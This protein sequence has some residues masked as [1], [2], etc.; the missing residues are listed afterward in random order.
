[1]KPILS[2]GNSIVKTA[3][4]GVALASLALPTLSQV[5]KPEPPGTPTATANR[6]AQAE[7][8]IIALTSN[9]NTPL[10]SRY[11]AEE[12]VLVGRPVIDLKALRFTNGE[13][14]NVRGCRFLAFSG[15]PQKRPVAAAGTR[16]PR[17]VEGG[18]ATVSRVGGAMQ[19]TGSRSV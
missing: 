7:Q 15:P 11:V 14:G 8:Q 9:R 19:L 13:T 18:R 2:S 3:I 5:K 10:S 12:A 17:C 16:E 6:T 4:L 1:M